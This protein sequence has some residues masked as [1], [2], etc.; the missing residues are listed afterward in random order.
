MV[1]VDT[2][3]WMLQI[4]WVLHLF[5][6]VKTRLFKTHQAIRFLVSPNGAE[7]NWRP[8]WQYI[9]PVRSLRNSVSSFTC[10][11]WISFGRLNVKSVCF[12]KWTIALFGVITVPRTNGSSRLKWLWLDCNPVYCIC[13][14]DKEYQ[15]TIYFQLTSAQKSGEAF[16]HFNEGQINF[17]PTYKFVNGGSEYDLRYINTCNKYMNTCTRKPDKYV[18]PLYTCIKEL[19]IKYPLF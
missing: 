19:S 1:N 9:H 14:K 16:Q 4:L 12:G 8:I 15:S 5:I 10:G 6:L 3:Q 13:T 2:A 18:S 17:P 11:L 7:H